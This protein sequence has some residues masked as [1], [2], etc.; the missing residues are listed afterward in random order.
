MTNLNL[1]KVTVFLVGA[2]LGGILCSFATYGA[3]D[4]VS[5]LKTDKFLAE[6]HTLA[7]A[8]GCGSLD[9]DSHFIWKTQTLIQKTSENLPPN[10]IC[11]KSDSQEA[12]N[13][14]LSSASATPMPADGIL[15]P[16]KM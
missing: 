3:V 5:Q 10:V 8:N 14:K 15:L 6:T 9:K 4:Y 7:I 12:C 11:G 16:S 13:K 1:S 2:I